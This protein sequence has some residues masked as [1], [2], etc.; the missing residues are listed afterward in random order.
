MLD[1][2]L[3]LLHCCEQFGQPFPAVSTTVPPSQNA[4]GPFAKMVG[5]IGEIPVSMVKLLEFGLRRLGQVAV[6]VCAKIGPGAA[7]WKVV[8][9]ALPGQWTMQL[10]QMFV[11]VMATG[12]PSQAS[13][14]VAEIAG[15]G[16]NVAAAWVT[17]TVFVKPQPATVSVAV[18]SVV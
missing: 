18:R 8:P 6:A 9:V 1:W 11:A 7:V 14:E 4:S 3:P 5:T 10:L 15:A 13:S 12:F 17:T 2:V 16:G